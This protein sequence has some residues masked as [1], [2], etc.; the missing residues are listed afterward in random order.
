METFETQTKKNF[1]KL[2]TTH[3]ITD[4]E[5]KQ[6]LKNGL[7]ATA[8]IVFIKEKY[9]FHYAVHLAESI[10]T[11]AK[12]LTNR[13]KSGVL[14]YKVKDSFVNS[15]DDI[16]DNELKPKGFDFLSGPYDI[17]GI[18]DLLDKVENMKKDDFP[19]GALRELLTTMYQ[20]VEKANFKWSRILKVNKN[21]N[22]FKKLGFKENLEENSTI[23]DLI[24]IDSLTTEN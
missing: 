5:I 20:N 7:T 1:S 3:K 9:P 23:Y 18:E 8:G 4:E 14:F 11:K 12:N 16:I 15:Y 19:K 21:N 13:E 10:T 22:S 2:L 24:T 6:N 17:N